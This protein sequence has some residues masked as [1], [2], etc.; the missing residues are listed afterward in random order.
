MRTCQDTHWAGI[1]DR[2]ELVLDRGRRAIQISMPRGHPWHRVP[3]QCSV[4]PDRLRREAEEPD[5]IPI[6]LEVLKVLPLSSKVDSTDAERY[7]ERQALMLD[8]VE[9]T[10]D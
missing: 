5:S 7:V 2:N 1:L 3:C 9:R 8:F 10:G 6:V 4:L